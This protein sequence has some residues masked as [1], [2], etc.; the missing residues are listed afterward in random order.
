[1]NGIT[2]DNKTNYHLFLKKK[3]REKDSGREKAG[4]TALCLFPVMQF[5][6]GEFR[7]ACRRGDW[8]KPVCHY[9]QFK[10]GH[11]FLLLQSVRQLPF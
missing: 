7:S 5:V 1:M 6:S 11:T 2:K 10:Y 8:I 3:K 4:E 9:L